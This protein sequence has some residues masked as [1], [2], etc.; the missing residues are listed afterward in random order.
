MDGYKRR[1][2]A[3]INR[4]LWKVTTEHDEYFYCTVTEEYPQLP[5]GHYA[6]PLGSGLIYIDVIDN[7][8]IKDGVIRTYDP[9]IFSQIEA[10]KVLLKPEK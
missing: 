10:L 3:T 4:F 1:D 5:D 7:A 8:T 9:D 6:E 2:V